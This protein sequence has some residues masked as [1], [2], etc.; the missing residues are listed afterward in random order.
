MSPLVASILLAATVSVGV[1]PPEVDTARSQERGSTRVAASA[2]TAADEIRRRVKEGQKIVIVDDQ[3]RE[4]TGRI[5]ELRADA[6]MLLV[7]R[8]RTDVPYDRILR[9]DRPRDGLSDGALI[10]LGIGAGLG[11]GLAAAAEMDDS[12]FLDFDFTDVAPIAIPVLGGIG[13]VIGLAL[14]ASIRREPNLYRRQGETLSLAPT[15]VSSRRGVAIA[16]SW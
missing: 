16:V 7:D 4:L 3:G 6:L 12:G 2:Q 9:I 13:A 5:G 11:L 1:N 14:D 8:D 15:L 10:G